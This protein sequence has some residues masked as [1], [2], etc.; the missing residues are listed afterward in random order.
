LVNFT[1]TALAVGAFLAGAD[2][3][4]FRRCHCEM[5]CGQ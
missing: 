2:I 1:L 4:W 5:F 3:W